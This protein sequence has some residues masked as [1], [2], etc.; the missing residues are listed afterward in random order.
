MYTYMVI[1]RIINIKNFIYK[2]KFKNKTSYVQS[3]LF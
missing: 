1:I 3:V 2:I